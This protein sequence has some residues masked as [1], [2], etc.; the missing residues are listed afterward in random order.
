MESGLIECSREKGSF[1]AQ[2][3][4]WSLQWPCL[5][6]RVLSLVIRDFSQFNQRSKSSALRAASFRRVSHYIIISRCK[7]DSLNSLEL[8]SQRALAQELL[9]WAEDREITKF[10]V[11][12]PPVYMFLLWNGSLSLPR[13]FRSYV[14]WGHA[15]IAAQFSRQNATPF[16]WRETKTVCSK[17]VA[18]GVKKSSTNSSLTL[19]TSFGI[20]LYSR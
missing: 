1:F 10:S 15:V 16:L 12:C 18:G 5:L 11:K 2:F 20:F 7:T 4:Q 17:T 19:W 6:L 3:D 9:F 8:V 13:S 14:L